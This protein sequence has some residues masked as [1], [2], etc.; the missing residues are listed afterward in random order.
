M[1]DGTLT[2]TTNDGTYNQ[3]EIKELLKKGEAFRFVGDEISKSYESD[4][5]D[6][7]VEA[8][9]S[10]D[11]EDLVGDIM[12]QKAL[13]EMK[14]GFIGKTVFMNHRTSVPD[15]VF[16]AVIEAQIIKQNGAQL[17][18]F[19]IIVE[20]ENEAAMKTWRY[21]NGG[22]VKLGTSVTVLVNK[23]TPNPNRKGGILIDSVETIEHSIVGVPCN[24]EA[25]TIAATASKAL[26]LSQLLNHEADEAPMKTEQKSADEAPETVE[27]ATEES[28]EAVST[29]ETS[30][31]E[32]EQ[33]PVEEAPAEPETPAEEAAPAAEEKSL[34]SRSTAA[35]ERFKALVDE[36]TESKVAKTKAELPIPVIKGLFADRLEHPPFWDLFDILCDV[37]WNLLSQIWNLQYAGETDFSEVEAAWAESL[38]EFMAAAIDS[39][40]FWSIPQADSESAKSMS[41][42]DALEIEATMKGLAGVIAKTADAELLAEF[43]DVGSSL[44]EIASKGGIEIPTKTV[45]FDVTKSKEFT[46]MATRAETAEAKVKELS[47]TL[48]ET[49]GN[50][51]VAKAGLDVAVEAL[52]ADMRKPLHATDKN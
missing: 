29:E 24:R 25:N 28:S 1:A 7:F 40:S 21:I 15:D 44:I 14:V 39:F 50:L 19:K 10:S 36:V 12:T 3:N 43:R 35:F 46:D 9:A 6:Y 34:F 22:R 30:A 2:K 38:S 31:D 11:Q 26:E 33:A 45:E 37:R 41:R 48:E 51:E 52:E 23:S 18:I 20:K 8:V 32:A 42:E 49:Q 27:T 17:L 47:T 4:E 13:Q 5:G 16:G